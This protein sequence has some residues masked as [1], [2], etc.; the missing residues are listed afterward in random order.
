MRLNVYTASI[1]LILLLVASSIESSIVF[2]IN[3][4]MSSNDILPIYRFEE[5]DKVYERILVEKAFGR[6]A[7]L[8]VELID[9][10]EYV[11]DNGVRVISDKHGCFTII[12]PYKEYEKYENVT[13]DLVREIV[14]RI[15]ET[16]V[17]VSK[18]TMVISG[19]V[20]NEYGVYWS[21]G[22]IIKRLDNGT[23]VSTPIS[24]VYHYS[25]RVDLKY[26]VNGVE[27][28]PTP[29]IIVD[30]EG[31]IIGGGFLLSKLMKLGEA[32]IVPRSE[33]YK[34]LYDYA[35]EKYGKTLSFNISRLIYMYFPGKTLVGKP[36]LAPG[37]Y[38]LATYSNALI[39]L[40]YLY[41]EEK[42]K[43]IERETIHLSPGSG[44]NI[45]IQ[46]N[47]KKDSLYMVLDTAIYVLIIVV[48]TLNI[49]YI[50]RMKKRVKMR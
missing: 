12:G 3:T 15:N 26:L 33:A 25:V 28:M 32:N 47:D 44:G 14:S 49:I 29:Y 40:S 24:E 13:D 34:K 5:L 2:S 35:S 20:V 16:L 43:I 48:A 37:Y 18:G 17:E 11:L 9:H 50:L 42:P 21:E 38:A 31:D 46:S 36:V 10:R 41:L 22:S 30:Y 4:S 39:T 8:S 23:L 6:K 7:R 27:V 45:M 1:L 19:Y